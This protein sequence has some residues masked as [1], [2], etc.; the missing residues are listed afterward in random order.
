MGGNMQNN[1]VDNCNQ[2][3]FVFNNDSFSS[4][5]YGIDQVKRLLSTVFKDPKIKLFVTN[6]DL[7]Q[8]DQETQ[9][10]LIFERDSIEIVIRS[11]ISKRIYY[12]NL[13]AWEFFINDEEK[14]LGELDM[15]IEKIQWVLVE[16][17]N[18]RATAYIGSYRGIKGE[19]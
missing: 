11:D 12:L 10:C 18:C 1:Y 9:Y 4:V 17:E 6:I 19:L 2:N 15:F 3:R 14:S 13:Q 8:S 7:N 5:L 16:L